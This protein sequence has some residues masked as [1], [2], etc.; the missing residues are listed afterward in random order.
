MDNPVEQRAPDDAASELARLHQLVDELHGAI[1]ARDDFIAIAAHELRNPLTPI[2]GLAELALASVR[3]AE[4]TV[5]PRVTTILEKMQFAVQEFIKRATRLLDVTRIDSGNFQLNPATTNLSA[6]VISVA[7]RYEDKA[8]HGQNSLTLDIEDAVTGEWD[9]LA[10]EQVVENLLSNALKFG[11]GKPVTV[12][13]RWSGE[14][15]C[16]EVQDLGIGMQPEQQA[17]I[18]G[19]FEQVMTQHQGGGFGIGLW[20]SARLVAA[21]NGR[22]I[23]SSRLGEGSTFTAMLPLEPPKPDRPAI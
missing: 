18:F 22:L 9:H 23:V 15:A 7:H 8:A 20:V 2:L 14:S 21:M 6:L 3:A 12:R 13:V 16:V 1:R 19:R 17:R 11:T 10:V 4:G 5:P